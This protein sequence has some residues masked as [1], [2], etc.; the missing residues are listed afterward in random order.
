[1]AT[2]Q[3]AGHTVF[4]S[5]S[6]QPASAPSRALRTGLAIFAWFSLLSALAG[7]IGLTVGGGFGL[8]SEWLAGSVFTS[9]FWPGVILGVV[10]GG[11]QILALAA[12]SVADPASQAGPAGQN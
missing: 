4:Y 3:R 2:E 8:P 7:M 1:M 11:V 12:E 9:Y 10:V 6:M 5:D